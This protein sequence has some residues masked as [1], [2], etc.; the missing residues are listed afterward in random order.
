[1]VAPLNLSQELL[2]LIEREILHA[3]A[4]RPA[5]IVAK[6]N[7]LLDRET[8]EAL[9]AASKAGVEI[10][11]IVRGICALRPGVKG[12]SEHIRVR[13][14]VGRYLEHS[15]IFSF[16]NGGH[17]EVFCGSADWMPRNLFDRCEVLFPVDD[18]A[19]S[20]RLRDEILG[21]YLKDNVKARLL[22][23][24]GTYVRAP[25]EGATFNAQ[26]YLMEIARA[27]RT[28]PQ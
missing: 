5:A 12:L 28:E 22:Q 2:K 16:A 14:I 8:I 25:R 4:R 15:R 13:S 7:A 23:P 26:E 27:A 17:P 19:L 20:A 18:P 21:S 24:N 11:L 1:M 9:Y 3:R 6:M 10:D